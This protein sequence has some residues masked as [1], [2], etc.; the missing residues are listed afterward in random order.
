MPLILVADD[1]SQ[2][3]GWL[4][5]ILED[6]GY[7]VE[8]VV[9]GSEALAF[10]KRAEP[11]LVVLDLFMPNMDGAE[12]LLYLR[13]SDRPI[14]VLAISG[15][16]VDDYDL[17]QTAIVLGAHAAMGKPFSAKEFLQRVESLLC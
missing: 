11:A 4:R 5:S 1:D 12:V 15:H 10:L 3:R 7:Q 8:E 2:L 6:K 14:K 9:D 17:S 16:I 13:S